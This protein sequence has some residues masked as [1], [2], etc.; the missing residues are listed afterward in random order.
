MQM[1][2]HISSLLKNFLFQV[3]YKLVPMSSFLKIFVKLQVANPT[4][5]KIKLF[6]VP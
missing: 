2:S 1:G 3:F 6:K 5:E 4:H